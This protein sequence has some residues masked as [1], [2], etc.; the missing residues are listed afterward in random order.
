M[1]PPPSDRV[2]DAL[3]RM[4][5]GGHSS[6]RL[7]GYINGTE[8]DDLSVADFLAYDD[9][10][11]AQQLA[12]AGWLRAFLYRASA[13]TC[14]RPSKPRH[15]PFLHGGG[16][17]LE[18]GRGT[19]RARAAI[20]DRARPWF[21]PKVR[22]VLRPRSMITSK[23]A[24]RLPLGVA[25][26]VFLSLANPDSVPAESPSARAARSGCDR[27]LLSP[28]FGRPVIE[29]FSRWCLGTCAGGSGRGAA[30]SASLLAN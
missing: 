22:Y 19:L 20:A 17:E 13:R 18:T 11:S 7:S 21:W 27:Q 3:A 2:G 4:I 29:C 10:A 28:P 6:T 5:A 24:A 30:A 15:L 8:L 25:D 12:I 23:A 16:V 26:K 1:I 14:Q 9:A